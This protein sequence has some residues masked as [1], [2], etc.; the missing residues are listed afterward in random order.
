MKDQRVKMMNEILSGVKVLKLLPI[1]FLPMIIIFMVQAIVS[2]NRLDR[3]M[4]SEEID[5]DSVTHDPTAKDPISIENGSFAWEPETIVLKNINLSVRE[6]EL[7]A[8]VGT[9]GSGKSSLLASML[10]ELDKSSGKVNTRGTIA[11]VPQQ[12]W[13]QNVT[14]RDNILF[15]RPFEPAKYDKVIDACALKPDLEILPGRDQTEIGEKGINLSG[16]Q[17][18]RVSLARATYNNSEVYLFDDPL[19]AVDSHDGEISEYGTYQELLDKKGAFSEFLMHHIATADDEELD[20]PELLKELEGVVGPIDK[21]RKKAHKVSDGAVSDG[22][23]TITELSSQF[24]RKFST[25]SKESL[26]SLRRQSKELEQKAVL[27]EKEKAET[28]GVKFTVYFD[29]FRAAGWTMTFFT[30]LFYL[31]FQGLSVG[32]NLW[33]TAW[34]NQPVE[35]GT[36]S[37]STRDMYLGVYGA[38]GAMQAFFSFTGTLVMAL[39]TLK[40]SALFHSDML[41]RILRSPMSFFDTTPVGRIVNRFAKDVDVAD[42][43]LPL[44]IRLWLNSFYQ[45]LATL[46]VISYSTPIFITVVIPIG[47]LYYIVQR[48]FVASTRQ[49]K[50]ME[51]VSRSPIYSHF[52]ETIT[53]ASTIRAY[54]QNERFIMDSETKVD[55]NQ[56]AYF[57]SVVANRWLQVR[58]ESVG[59]LVILFAAFFAVMGRET[60]DPGTVGLSV[61]YAL[62]ITIALNMLVRWTSEVETNIVAIERLQEYREAIQE[63]PWDVPSRTPPKEWPTEGVVEFDHYQTRYREGLD[64]VLRNVT[65]RIES[66]EKIGIVG[67]TGAGKSSLTLG[68]FRIVEAAG[69]S[70]VIDGVN[71]SKIGLHDVRGRLTIIPQDP[72]LFSGTL[73]V[74]L[75]PFGR[76]SDQNIWQALELAHLKAFV[77]G[78]SAGLE[79]EIS[80]G[81]DNLSVGQRQLVCLARALL[82]KTKIL[83]LDE[84][85]AAV[86]LE[87]DDLIQATIRK[88]FAD[89]T[90]ITIAHRL[91]TIM[92]STRVMVLDQV[93]RLGDS[94]TPEGSLP[95]MVHLIYYP[96]I[97]GQLLINCWADMRPE[98]EQNPTVLKDRPCLE[99]TRKKGN[100][101]KNEKQITSILPAL[102]GAFGGMFYFGAALKIIPDVMAFVSPQI[103]NSLIDFINTGGDVWKGYF[104]A[105]VMPY[106]PP[107]LQKKNQ[108]Q[109]K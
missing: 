84:A 66:G 90:V 108:Q 8:V 32:S 50:R 107:M 62:Q 57:P 44:M 49:L 55:H 5:P 93:I 18:Q 77:K 95:Y 23:G 88:E 15:G 89:S 91:N 13:I 72:V 30:F 78:L 48:M 80:E 60:L 52:G 87:T 25:A 103:L 99:K 45:V 17:K 105:A 97:V 46:V 67:R 14:L 33:L 63:A 54:G 61:S 75:D 92:D 12:A 83:I 43:T 85:T 94:A 64:L 68:L 7:L 82:R 100:S 29:Y 1:T 21:L 28:A 34:S 51:S 26:N 6:G 20:D 74:N 65:C 35:N 81:G 56:V 24:Q 27:I 71:I 40:S 58:L 109:E 53:G 42:N 31:L 11:Y 38:L 4:N 106:L 70:I 47:L 39:G 3:Y 59:N 96:L 69:G 22:E 19:S 98:Y 102:F 73:R 9:V 101:N 10:G 2:L 37:T 79:Y 16:G 41:N 86:D 76:Y 104:L 36:V